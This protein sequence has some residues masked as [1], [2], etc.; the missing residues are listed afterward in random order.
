M[1]LSE[2]ELWERWRAAILRYQADPTPEN[3]S[4]Q[5]RHRRAFEIV[6]CGESADDE[7]DR[8]A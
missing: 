8:A 4:E 5:Q 3:F 7:A 1:P 2:A 6:F